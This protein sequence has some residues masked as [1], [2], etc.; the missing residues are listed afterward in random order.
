[1]ELT[2]RI[3][4]GLVVAALWVSVGGHTTRAE[5]AMPAKPQQSGMSIYLLKDPKLHA[6]QAMK[7]PLAALALRETPWIASA[8]I[9]RYDVSTHFVH[10]KQPVKKAWERISLGGT[11][12]VVTADGERRY[13]GTL[14]T[15]ISSIAP[16]QG[17][18]V[19][20]NPV[21][22]EGSADL[23]AL[24]GPDAV[25][26]DERVLRALKRDG[27]L[28]AGIE[29]TLDKVVVLP[30]D[31]GAAIRYT[32]TVRNLDR[33]ALYVLDTDRMVYDWFRHYQN[34]IAAFAVPDGHQHINRPNPL[35]GMKKLPHPH[36]HVDPA[37]FVRLGSG[38]SMTRTAVEPHFRAVPAGRYRCILRYGY[39]GCGHGFT[40]RTTKAQR[41]REDGRVWIGH[42]TA[43][44]AVEVKG[45]AEF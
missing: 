38:E 32:Y 20:S 22:G 45:A 7:I 13:L 24:Q 31:A 34:G 10:L 44:L 26:R 29:C 33:E 5:D 2:S 30:Q 40:G 6:R 42:L 39:P 9:E 19:I 8:N 15:M 28:S 41:Q 3:A 27:L 21:W 17:L 18:P 35:L 25:L 43:S 37:W 16:P 11:P 4:V 14:T 36:G 12:F 1:M 23:I